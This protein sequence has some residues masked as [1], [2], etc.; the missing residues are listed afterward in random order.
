MSIQVR[1][2]QKN[3]G[4]FSLWIPHDQPFNTEQFLE[5]VAQ[6]DIQKKERVLESFGP[7]EI[8]DDY[9]TKHGVFG[10][11][12]EFDEFMGTTI[13]SHPILIQK[14]WTIMLAS[15]LFRPKD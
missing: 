4:G 3:N 1:K 13:Y 9:H 2:I 11:H 5:I 6:L 12:Y 15:G 8:I 14:I 10:I 7:A